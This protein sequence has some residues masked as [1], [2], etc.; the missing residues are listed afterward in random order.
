MRFQKYRSNQNKFWQSRQPGPRRPNRLRNWLGG[1]A[2]LGVIIAIAAAL[3][4]SRFA[5]V[6][7]SGRAE[8]IDGD[9]LRM[10]GV[11]MRLKGI[12]APEYGQTCKDASGR[13]QPCGRTA[14]RAL[15]AILQMGVVTCLHNEKDRYG[16]ALVTCQSGM[17]DIGAR[18]VREG[19]AIAYGNYQAEEANA[20]AA[21][22]GIWA[23]TFERPADWR[24]R[25]PRGDAPHP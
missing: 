4:M 22:R 2:M 16:R 19:V 5:T 3:E 15:A 1:L 18:L 20:R 9:S 13:E 6:E 10:N 21:K 8:A 7:Q 11:E 24:Q 23:G 14:R 25:H 17:E 12:D